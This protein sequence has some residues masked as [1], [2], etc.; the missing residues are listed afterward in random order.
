MRTVLGGV[1]APII[2]HVL[3]F[4]TSLNAQS[5]DIWLSHDELMQRPNTGPSWENLLN[6][7]EALDTTRVQGGHASVHDVTTMA[8]ALVAERLNDDIRRQKVV[9]A[10]D[11]AITLN[12]E[13]DGNSLSLSRSVAGY[14]LA[15]D[16]IDLKNVAPAVDARFRIWL[17]HVIYVLKLDNA[18][19][20]EKHEHR[21]NNHGTQAGVGRIAAAIYLDKINDL[22]RAALVFQGWLGDSSAY[23]GFNWGDL[24]WQ[25]DPNHPVGILPAGAKKL[26]ANALRDVDGVQPDDQRRAGCPDEEVSWPPRTDTHVWGGLQGAIGQA[27]LLSRQ[28]FDAWSWGNQAVLR[29]VAWQQDPLRGNAPAKDDDVWS[30]ALIDQVYGTNYWS[31]YPSDPGKQ[32]GWTDWTHGGRKSTLFGV[33]VNIDGRGQVAYDLP[34]PYTPGTVVQLHAV[35][36]PGWIFVGWDED[37][38]SIKNP[39]PLVMDSIKE[40]TAIFSEEAQTGIVSPIVSTTPS[41]SKADDAVIWVHP[42]KPEKSVVITTDRNKGVFIW[43]MAGNVLQNLPQQ[44]KSYNIDLRHNVVL[45]SQLVDVVA[46]NM[47]QV[48]KLAVFIVNP[49]YTASDV[50]IQIA[51]S[52]SA[53][54]NVQRETWGFCLYKRPSDNTLYAFEKPK[55]GGILRQYRIQGDGH[56]GVLITP[57]RDLNYSGGRAKGLVADDQLGFLYV[58]ESSRGIHKFLA[59]P[60]QSGDPVSFF[61]KEDGI[62]PGRNSLTLYSCSDSTGYLVLTSTG[63]STLKYYERYGQN[64]F[65][66]TVV[67]TDPFGNLEILSVA[68]AA[69]SSFAGPTFPQG[70]LVAQDDITEQF[71]FYDWSDVAGLDLVTCVDGEIPPLPNL[72]IQ[73]DSYNFGRVEIHTTITKAFTVMNTGVADLAVTSTRLIDNENDEMSIVSGGAPFIVSPNHSLD[74]EV[75]FNPAAIGRTQ[76][77]LRIRTNDRN[78]SLIDI[79]ITGTGFIPRPEIRVAPDAV[80]Y[81]PVVVGSTAT[82]AL[83]VK[84]SGNINLEINNIEFVQGNASSFFLES[85]FQPFSIAPGD[86]QTIDIDFKPHSETN[87]SIV[88]KISSNDLTRNPYSVNITG[89]GFVQRPAIVV[90]PSVFDFGPVPLDTSALQNFAVFNAGTADLSISAITLTAGNNDL[91]SI[92]ATTLPLILTPGDTHFIQITFQPALEG[93]TGTTLRF[94]SNDAS[95]NPV[96]V[97]ISGSGVIPALKTKT[98]PPSDDAYVRSNRA[99]TLFGAKPTLFVRKTRTSEYRSYLKFVVNGLTGAVRR[100][101][102]RIFAFDLS[103]D[104]GTVHLV[105]N[106]FEG[107][108]TPWTE[109]GIN[110]QNAP[111]INSQPLGAIGPLAAAGFVEVDVTDIVRGNG[112]FSFAL[113]NKSSD[114]VKYKSKE[115]RTAP[116]LVIET[117]HVG[118]PVQLVLISGNNQSAFTGSA[119]PLPLVVE[120][121][122]AD[123]FPASGV[124]VTFT[125]TSGG[126]SFAEAEQQITGSDGRAA[127]TLTLGPDP[128][129]NT[130]MAESVGLSGSPQVFTATGL[131]SPRASQLLKMSGDHQTGTIDSTLGEPFVVKTLDQNGA[132]IAGIPVSF[133]IAQGDGRLSMSLPRLT[134]NQGFASASLTLGPSPGRNTVT[135]SVDGLTPVEFS[136]IAI[137]PPSELTFTPVQDGYVRSSRPT[138]DYGIKPDLVVRNTSTDYFSFLKFNVV[139]LTGSVLNAKLRL[140]VT[141][142][143]PDGGSVFPVSNLFKDS[144]APWEERVLTWNNAPVISGNPLAVIGQIR[145]NTWIEVDVTTAFSGNGTVSFGIKNNHRNRIKYSSRQGIHPPEL[146]IQTGELQPATQIVMI[147]GTNQSA[148]V[149][150]TLPQPFVVEARDANGQPVRDVEVVFSV[151]AGGGSLSGSLTRITGLDGRAA[152]TLTLGSAAGAN[153]VSASAAGLS[154]SPLIFNAT[155]TPPPV[156]EQLVKVSGDEQS[157]PAGSPLSQPMVARVL[158]TGNQ[159]ASGV[160]ISFEV[161]TGGGHLSNSQPQ[162]TDENGEAST[163]LTL[164]AATGAHIVRVTTDALPDSILFFTATGTEPPS[165]LTFHPIADTYARSSRPT[166]DYGRKLH[167]V[168]RKSSAIQHSFIKFEVSNL[169][170]AVQSAKLRLYVTDPSSDGGAIYSVSNNYV[171]NSAPWNEN[172]LNWRNKPA[173]EGTPLHQFGAA[174]LNEWV[175]A[176]VTLAIT[177][178]GAFSFGILNTVRDRIK[179]SSKEGSHP[180]ELFITLT[181]NA[182][183]AAKSAKDSNSD[184]NI[185]PDA[186]TVFLP[187]EFELLGNY[188]NPF[189]PETTIEYSLP[190]EARVRLSIYNM[191]GQKVRELLDKRQN[192]GFKKITWD[193]HDRVG[194]PVSSGIYFIRLEVE[195]RTFIRKMVLQK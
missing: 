2:F 5:K 155:A 54:N 23:R 16:L 38:L 45:G 35:P 87:E 37:I 69:T 157:G 117:G 51:D 126:G 88:L 166:S 93:H 95:H 21:G 20:V 81:G 91:F 180:P 140:Y 179:Y 101:T 116:K 158:E 103:D 60:G 185:R 40:V 34:G 174:H 183:T 86:S 131:E 145:V 163:L 48:G 65:V 18:T 129:E 144:I 195:S 111:A 28:G 13:N 100:A 190:R 80:D 99:T 110:W 181:T 84:S 57:V 142:D 85:P 106:D 169:N 168:V 98:F 47:R 55:R 96:D 112:T 12:I 71:H 61:A 41:P 147:S 17:E 19:Q 182:S 105:A 29:A 132:A 120:V 194:N 36:A 123:N 136:A 1:C 148:L 94:E 184:L 25:L 43:D 139:G 74:I 104:G 189:N 67:P 172:D 32:V 124:P 109:A 114:L 22:N 125:V 76:A 70:L 26:V 146:I 63:N 8:A 177:G 11:A 143:G 82:Q 193:G 167:L 9:D 137:L 176:D 161:L 46:L 14:I 3:L 171:D 15:A 24:C 44:T 133:T 59:S 49:D 27:Y 192:P 156:P 6:A 134:D 118:P 178:N 97:A 78:R 154:G 79:N 77:D 119:A 175:E 165:E 121:R 31:G 173:I 138:S 52:N 149:G 33:R 10:I 152:V 160:A 135:A 53:Q 108:S 66:K 153:T 89:S 30:L 122:D 150:S 64:R 187:Q 58:A 90:E 83:I 107:T 113:K 186:E 7:A 72:V 62:L 141:D 164:G 162:I 42:T 128:G 115:G 75:S 159:P 188:P 73:P 92:G 102:L 68:V 127:V 50:L 39:A 56:G 4:L 191:L 130:V 151:M 170:G